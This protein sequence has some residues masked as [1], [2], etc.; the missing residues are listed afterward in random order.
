MKTVFHKQFIKQYSKLPITQ[1]RRFEEII[2]IFRNDPTNPN[3]YN[4]PLSGEWKN[5]R[6]IAFGGDWRAHYIQQDKDT[7]RFVAVGKHSQLYK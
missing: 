4:H 5:H 2:I 7:A 3:L 6:S 1:K